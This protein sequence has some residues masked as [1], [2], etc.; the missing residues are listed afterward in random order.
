MAPSRPLLSA[1]LQLLSG[2]V[3]AS[4]AAVS[5]PPRG[6]NNYCAHLGLKN[7]SVQLQQAALQARQ[8]LPS[9]YDTSVP[10]E[11][12]TQATIVIVLY[13]MWVSMAG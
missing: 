13:N 12:R 9:G 10:G 5:V 6:W 3:G 11:P 4:A 2:A 1:V 8:L 7:E